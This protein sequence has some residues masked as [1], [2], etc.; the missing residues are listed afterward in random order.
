MTRHFVL[1]VTAANV[2]AALVWT[3]VKAQSPTPPPPPAQPLVI[4]RADIE[5]M[6]NVNKEDTSL[7]SIDAGRHVVDVWLDQ[8]NANPGGERNG[9]VH[10]ELTEIYVVQKGSAK[11]NDGGG[12]ERRAHLSHRPRPRLAGDQSHHHKLQ[13]DQ[14]A[15]R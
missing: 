1:M 7:G 6:L 13:S 5:H 8:R 14:R 9:Q 10:S 3:G 11:M 12:G 2:V 15:G 4:T